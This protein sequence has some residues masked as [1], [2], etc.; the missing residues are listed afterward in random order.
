MKDSTISIGDSENLN[1]LRLLAFFHVFLQHA[2]GN[3]NNP[4]LHNTIIGKALT[5]YSYGTYTFLLLSGYLM[6][7]SIL[8]EVHLTNQLNVRHFYYRRWLRIWPLY[9]GFISFVFLVFPLL[10][11]YTS[12]TTVLATH[13][14]NYYLFLANFDI[15]QMEAASLQGKNL[16]LAMTW[17]LSVLEQFYLVWPLL[18]VWIAPR[19][20]GAIFPIMLFASLGFSFANA[21]QGYMLRLHTL[22]ACNTVVFGGLLSFLII[23]C[24]EFKSAIEKMPKYLVVTAYIVGFSISYFGATFFKG[25][26]EFILNNLFH[27]VLISFIIAEQSF[28]R[29]SFFKLSRWKT[30]ANWAKYGLGFYLF[31]MVA[32]FIVHVPFRLM[33][34][35]YNDSFFLTTIIA[36]VAFALTLFMSYLSYEYF[37]KKF[38]NLKKRFYPKPAMHKV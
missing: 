37:E 11:Q 1:T 19:F 23:R 4:L 25:R 21:D 15:L 6:T 13:P 7:F 8:K 34:I 28:C 27:V 18:F 30:L 20:Y 10:N 3:L 14:I 12:T 29:N 36:L 9:F 26:Y 16:A 35:S 32:L 2:Y 33:N 5:T 24:K 38:I 31:H 17:T 22:S